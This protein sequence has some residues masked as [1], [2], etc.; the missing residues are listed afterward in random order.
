M[1]SFLRASDPPRTKTADETTTVFENGR[2]SVQ[3]AAPGSEYIMTQRIPPTTKEHGASLLQPPF[4]YHLYQ[5]EHF[6]VQSGRASFFT[7]LGPDPAVV[8]SPD[9]VTT[10]S[11]KAGT[12]HRFE[13]ASATEDLVLDIKLTPETYEQEQRFFRNFF[14][15]LDDCTKTKT[16]PSIFQLLVFLHGADTPLVIP[17]PV[18]WLGRMLSRILLSGGAAWGRYVLGYQPSYEEYYDDKKTK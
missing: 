12:Y 10:T 3:F 14:S 9:G 16:P 1:L 5:D 2:S 7:G 11:V 17:L 18:E 15:Y 4:H 6:R 8:L 13:N